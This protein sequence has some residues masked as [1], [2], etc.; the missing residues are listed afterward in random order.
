[1]MLSMNSNVAASSGLQGFR[2][3]YA[4]MFAA[5]QKLASG[6]AINSAADDPAGLVISEQLRSRIGSLNAEIDALSANINRYETASSTISEMQD[7]LI[8]LRTLAVAAVNEGGNSEEAQQACATAANDLTK[9]Y[10][11]LISSADYGS[12]KLFGTDPGALAD[13]PE[14]SGVDLSNP[15]AAAD[16]LSVIDDAQRN[17]SDTQMALAS[18]EKYSLQS[19]RDS[20]EVTRENLIAAESRLR[21]T[22]Y[23]QTYSDFVASLIQTRASVAML[24]HANIAGSEIVKLL[25]S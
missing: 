21:D 13:I 17:L 10:N 2:S 1:M 18:E 8:E 5:M 16:S 15:E 23:A 3:G 11:D 6:F 12:Q 25:K 19:R 14:L 24:A 7:Q 22:D 4:R 9:R 20:L